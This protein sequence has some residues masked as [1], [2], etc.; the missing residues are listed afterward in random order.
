M[1]RSLSDYTVALAVLL[2]SAVLLGALTVAMSGTNLRKAGR[3]VNVDFVDAAGVKVH[4]DVRYA[5]AHV[6][7]VTGIRHL[8]PAE[9]DANSDKSY[10]VRVTAVI[11]DSVPPIP[12][13][14]TAGLASETLL[15]EKFL[16]FTGG[17]P[18]APPL[19]DGAQLYA[20]GSYSIDALLATVGPV[21]EN[22][23][24]L[25]KDLRVDLD[26]L[27]KKVDTLVGSVDTLATEGKTTLAEAKTLLERADKLIAD[28]KDDIHSRLEELHEV[29]GALQKVLTNADGLVSRTD[30]ELNGRLQDMEVV[31]Q[32][33]KVV[34]THAKAITQTLGERPWRLIWGSRTPNQLPSEE[35]ILRSTKPLPAMV[36]PPNR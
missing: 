9:R 11:D 35:E 6:G 31:L 20:R 36:T 3:T 26:G 25:I 27:L 32:N 28:N 1:K 16:A 7:H 4:T 8:S 24:G 21:L 12:S 29:F 30:S 22:A 5:G 34:S 13:D 33:L 17:T 23:N 19:D 15:S 14:V 2:C 18:D 10:V